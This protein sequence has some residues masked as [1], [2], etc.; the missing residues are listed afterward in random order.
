MPKKSRLSDKLAARQTALTDS[1]ASGAEQPE[2]RQLKSPHIKYALQRR[3]D[4]PEARR[5]EPRIRRATGPD[6]Q[7]QASNLSYRKELQ[8]EQ[9]ARYERE[10]D[11]S[12]DRQFKQP[13]AKG[14][15]ERKGLR[16]AATGMMV[17][18]CAY[19]V[20]LIFGVI[21]TEY[22]YDDAGEVVPKRVTVRQISDMREFSVLATQY[23]SCRSLY[24]QV[25]L[26]DCRYIAADTQEEKIVIGSEYWKALDTV[27][28]L[29]VQ[30]NAL[31]VPSK[32]ENIK[33][34]LLTW[35]QTYIAVYCQNM[36]YSISN[37]SEQDLQRALEYQDLTYNG[38]RIISTNLASM[39]AQVTGAE[40]DV[41]N[42]SSWTPSGF[43]Q[44]QSGGLLN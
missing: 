8:A 43:I 20:F 41:N 39:G 19:M 9:E 44:E 13:S 35:T 30:I 25:L 18:L 33:S 40:A 42:I 6:S 37:N 22:T 26:L 5:D 27:E 10:L 29:I 16:K 31:T 34:Q 32:Y 36:S 2:K 23:Y 3:A 1:G 24:E 21:S 11:E 7:V 38:F 4:T 12:T 17:L 15:L 28:S 14:F